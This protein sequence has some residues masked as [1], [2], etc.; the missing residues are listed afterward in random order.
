MVSGVLGYE[1]PDALDRNVTKPYREE[2][3]IR[4][5]AVRVRR[6]NEPERSFALRRAPELQALLGAFTALLQGDYAGIER[7]FT[8]T[9]TGSADAW[10]LSLSPKDARL[11]RRIEAIRIDGRRDVPRCFAL[12][13]NAQ[14]ASIM[15]LG[16]ATHMELHPP[17]TREW[18]ERACAANE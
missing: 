12:V 16:A 9:A 2:T 15:L 4:G 11:A 13:S 6:E 14:S 10:Q 7:A 8:V 17:L 1:G 5:T 3:E 18:L